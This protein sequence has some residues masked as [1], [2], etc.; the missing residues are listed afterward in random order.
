MGQSVS[1]KPLV[2]TTPYASRTRKERDD[3]T[4]K[5]NGIH[6]VAIGARLLHEEKQT[7]SRD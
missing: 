3:S 5:D 2:L 7:G 4:Y 1:E 6:Q